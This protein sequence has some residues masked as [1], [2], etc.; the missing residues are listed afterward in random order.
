M[1]ADY[2][3]CLGWVALQEKEGIKKLVKCGSATIPDT[4]KRN[5][6]FSELE[7]NAVL[8]SLKKMRLLTVGNPN[9]I[10][11]TDHLPL[12]GILKKPLDKI[13]TRRLMKMAEKL[14]SF[15]FHIEYVKGTKNEI[16]DALS[17]Y[18]IENDDEHE[19][20]ENIIELNEINEYEEEKISMKELERMAIADNQ[21]TQIREAIL[22][23]VRPQDL[24]PDHPGRLST[25]ARGVVAA[26]PPWTTAR[27]HAARRNVDFMMKTREIF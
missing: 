19:D 18:P 22:N 23:N 10:I 14:Q 5:F 2:K 27:R 15:S 11:R 3:A 25:W 13:E 24:P 21:Y 12:I 9:V 7:L 8:T 6:S 1:Q 17:R 20:L 16:A 4:V 26:L